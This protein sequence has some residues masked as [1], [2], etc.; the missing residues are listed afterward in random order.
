MSNKPLH[1][2]DL[3]ALIAHHDHLYYNLDQPEITDAEYDALKGQLQEEET[4]VPGEPSRLFEKYAHTHPI[5]SLAKVSSEEELRKEL[6]RLAPG[7][8]QP[9]LDGLT[10]V[11]YPDGAVVTR[12]NGKTGENVSHTA[13]TIQGLGSVDK[14]ALPVRI[15]AVIRKDTFQTLASFRQEAGK[16][17]FKNPR[18]AVAGMLRNKDASRVQGVTYKAY[19]LVGST[20][21]ES[22]QL[23][24]LSLLGYD[25]IESFPYNVDTVE[26]AAAYIL[27]FDRAAYPYETDGLV[28][29]SDIH[30]ALEVHGE[31]GHHPKSMVAF[32]FPSGGTWTHLT[33]IAWQVGR[34][35]RVTPVA[36][37]APVEVGGSTISRV[38]LHNP[39]IMEALGVRT[40]CQVFVTK[41]NDVIPAITQAQAAEEASPIQ[42]PTACP[43]CESQLQKVNGQLF[44]ENPDCY[45]KLMFSVCRMGSRDALDIAGLSEETAKKLIDAG[46]IQHPFDLFDVTAEQ[47]EALD[48]FARKSAQKLYSA[49]SASRTTSLDRFLYA[50]GL[51]HIGRTVAADIMEE[52]GTLDAFLEDIDK[53]A[54]RLAAIEGVGDAAVGSVRK[55]AHL[56]HK[57]R[58]KVTVEDQAVSAATKTPA[59]QLAF[60][61]TGTLPNPR[62]HYQDM[63][64]K[65]GHKVSDSISKNTDYLL[66]GEKAGSKLT[67]A[68]KL[69]VE[70]LDGEEALE[71]VLTQHREKTGASAAQG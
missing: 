43:T 66:A 52:F 41:A 13:A 38:T 55:Y 47:I 35:G 57:L 24:E 23:Q 65:A 60:V 4:T 59:R 67:K 45:A 7:V 39:G 49:V 34:S 42:V 51:A 19:N 37:I 27:H 53:G 5:K 69:G 54:D 30:N 12:G 8:I 22:L 70:V 15:E 11:I 33:G 28:I 32:K 36:E 48:G 6:I 9:K 14:T 16:E 10:L 46:L 63:I 29:K 44:C 62:S 64:R 71:R 2:S 40:G 26:E 17:L 61:I 56:F 18:N 58:E 68:S 21:P 25:T 1:Q 20:L 3:R 31:T 50:A